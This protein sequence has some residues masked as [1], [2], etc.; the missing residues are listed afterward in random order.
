MES[1]SV[2]LPAYSI[3]GNEVYKKIPTICRPYGT[4]IAVVGGQKAMAAAKEALLAG[5]ADSEMEILDFILYG[6]DAT[7]EAADALIANPV[8]QEAD[9]V[10]AVGGG[11]ALDTCKTAT[12]KIDKPLFTFPTIASNCA[13]VTLVC[14]MYKLDHSLSGFYYR[15]EPPKHSFINLDII[16]AA[17]LQYL[18]AGIG[19]A[20]GKQYEVVF[21]AQNDTLD[22][23]NLMGV[24]LA[25]NCAAPLLTYGVQAYEDAKNHQVSTALKEVVLNICITAGLISLLI[26]TERYN[27]AVPHAVYYAATNIPACEKNH[28]H[29]EIVGYGC[30]PQLFLEKNEAEF[31]RLFRFNRALDLPTSLAEI[32]IV[33]GSESYEQ[34]LDALMADTCMAYLPYPVSREMID[35]AI[36]GVEAYHHAHLT[37]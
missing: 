24:D 12:D 7:Y 33:I 3:G 36:Q 27:G 26:D 13:P 31:E 9:M 4:K 30:L 28:L 2:F 16:A 5:I 10:F 23:T 29:G 8:V 25:R 35:D 20:M 18:W 15:Q 34:F 32:D 21:S 17:P 11:R 14:I 37:V 1:Y 6:D 19:D 22:H